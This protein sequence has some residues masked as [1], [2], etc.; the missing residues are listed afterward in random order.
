MTG[1]RSPWD[2][3]RTLVLLALATGHSRAAASAKAGISDR[4]LRRWVAEDESFS[5]AVEV[6]MG[7]G[8]AVYEQLLREAGQKDW[9]AALAAYEVIYLGGTRGKAEAQAAAIVVTTPPP[10]ARPLTAEETAATLVHARDAV[11]VLVGAVGI[12][13][14]AEVIARREQQRRQIG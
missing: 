2:R 8:R 13:R 9:R 10:P 6:A 5:E 12:E 7:E 11:R 1:K 3:Q 4:T 14:A